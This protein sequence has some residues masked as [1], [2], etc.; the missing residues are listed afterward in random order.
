MTCWKCSCRTVHQCSLNK[1]HKDL[2][3]DKLAWLV[4]SP[5]LIPMVHHWNKLEPLTSI[6]C[7]NILKCPPG[8]KWSSIPIKT[9]PERLPR[10]AEAVTATQGEPTLYYSLRLKLSVSILS[11]I[12]HLFCWWLID[13]HRVNW[14]YPTEKLR[15]FQH[16]EPLTDASSIKL[17]V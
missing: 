14:N 8:T 11:N 13:H 2:D 17:P 15:S 16:V 6:S 1:V 9:N 7:S 12:M 3:V 5:D 4:L 10:R